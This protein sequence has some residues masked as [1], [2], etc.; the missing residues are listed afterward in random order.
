VLQAHQVL[1]YPQV[2]ALHSRQEQRVESSAELCL[3]VLVRNIF[4]LYYLA[5]KIGDENGDEGGEEER[6]YDLC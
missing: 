6:R 1:R 5:L 2:A 4:A 3:G